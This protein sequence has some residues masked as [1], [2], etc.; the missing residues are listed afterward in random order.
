MWSCCPPA[1]PALELLGYDVFDWVPVSDEGMM[2]LLENQVITVNNM[3]DIFDDHDL[4]NPLQYISKYIIIAHEL[5]NAQDENVS[6]L[7]RI[8]LLRNYRPM[9][10]AK[11]HF[12]VVTDF[13]GVGQQN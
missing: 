7:C 11:F 9:P 6:K 8:H 1:F 13:F 12:V 3:E 10:P 5:P 2:K 4:L